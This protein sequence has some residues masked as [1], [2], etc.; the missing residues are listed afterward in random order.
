M[1][2]QPEDF[3][4]KVKYSLDK[5]SKYTEN[6][7]QRMHRC[8]VIQRLS[9]MC[10]QKNTPSQIPPITLGGYYQYVIKQQVNNSDELQK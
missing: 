8:V 1:L 3:S 6:V 2:L 5:R 9:Q 7:V 4:I 10:V